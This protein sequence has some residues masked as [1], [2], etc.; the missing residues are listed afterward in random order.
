MSVYKRYTI[1]EP[2]QNL[3]FFSNDASTYT[4]VLQLAIAQSIHPTQIS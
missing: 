1:P 2:Q 4:V 3:P